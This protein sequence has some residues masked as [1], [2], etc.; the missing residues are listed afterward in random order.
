M[1][2]RVQAIISGAR[3]FVGG[4]EMR[5]ARG[6]IIR[7]NAMYILDEVKSVAN[8]GCEEHNNES[9]PRNGSKSECREREQR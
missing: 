3:G 7:S 4:S 6:D 8:D 1:C 2:V 5:A 9:I